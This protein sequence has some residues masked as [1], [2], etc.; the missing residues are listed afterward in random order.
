MRPLGNQP[1]LLATAPVVG[2]I[3]LLRRTTSSSGL[4]LSI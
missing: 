3:Q 1:Q 2:R 4:R